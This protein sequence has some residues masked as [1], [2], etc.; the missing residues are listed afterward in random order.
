MKRR[1]FIKAVLSGSSILLLPLSMGARAKNQETRSLRFGICTDI[2]QDIMHDAAIR[3]QQFL[4]VAEKQN[5]DFV[6]DLGDFCFPKNENL[7]FVKIWKSSPIEK[8]NV[9]GNHDMD[10]GNKN[11]FMN[12]VGMK[13]RYYSFDRGDIHFIVLDPNNLY[14][15]GNY[16]PYQN[17]NFYK[18]AEQRAHVDPAQMDW[19]K[20]DLSKTQKHC[21]VFS[22]QSFQNE[23]ACQNG[24]QVRAIFEEANR[25]AGFTKVVAAFSGHDHTDYATEINGIQYIQINSMSYQWVGEKYKC[26]ERF[27]DSIN[28]LRPSLQYTTPYKDPL[29]AIVTINEN[30]LELK[31]I[32]SSF[33]KPGPSELGIPT[34]LQSSTP[35]VARIS[36]RNFDFQ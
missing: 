25:N 29:F 34:N 23:T 2:H 6:I 33:V 12:F 4:D 15:D 20:N 7:D 14:I 22:H 30:S 16:I 8:F 35:L 18:P 32:E 28:K 27:P 31:G 17:G 11:D 5:L 1:Q 13:E 26:P 24:E 9:L 21:I 19:L 36:D 3:L 10:M